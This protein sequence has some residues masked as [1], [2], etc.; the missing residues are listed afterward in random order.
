MLSSSLFA[1]AG[2]G[3]SGLQESKWLTH[4]EGLFGSSE[5]GILLLFLVMV[6]I[7]SDPHFLHWV[8]LPLWGCLQIQSP[9]V[10]HFTHWGLTM[11]RPLSSVWLDC[12]WISEAANFPICP[13]EVESL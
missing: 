7:M 11:S 4:Q 13:M 8:I 6:Q 9:S 3:L 1:G 2:E 12:P 10:S 5:M